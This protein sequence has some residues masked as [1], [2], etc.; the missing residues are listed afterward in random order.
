MSK[1][2]PAV[3][4]SP[5]LQF[6]KT[7]EEKVRKCYSVSRAILALN[8][9]QE[10]SSRWCCCMYVATG[11]RLHW[12]LLDPWI[13]PY[14]RCLYIDWTAS[15]S[16]VAL[17]CHSAFH[18]DSKALQMSQSCPDIPTKPAFQ[19]L[20]LSSSLQVQ[21]YPPRISIRT[22]GIR[23]EIAYCMT[24][25]WFVSIFLPSGSFQ[26]LKL[27]SSTEESL[28]LLTS[29]QNHS[30]L[31]EEMNGALQQQWGPCSSGKNWKRPLFGA[32]VIGRS[33]GVWTSSIPSAST[34]LIIS[35]FWN[36]EVFDSVS[37]LWSE[38]VVDLLLIVFSMLEHFDW[39][40]VAHL[41]G[42][43]FGQNF[44]EI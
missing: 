3:F 35:S 17:E 39:S 19:Q 15:D 27:T 4:C 30:N 37:I 16:S 33:N 6:L 23:T 43:K 40:Q 25:T 1:G 10:A 14:W 29:M 20:T 8:Y 32:R 26:K 11:Q 28:P 18:M 41:H 21:I 9:S 31:G 24:Q 36:L 22:K 7:R 5:A 42:F 12:D 2:H 44:Y 13:C 38:F 34:I